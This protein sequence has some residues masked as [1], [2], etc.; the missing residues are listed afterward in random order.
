MAQQSQILLSPDRAPPRP[1]AVAPGASGLAAGTRDGQVGSVRLFVPAVL[2]LLG[3]S[4]DLPPVPAHHSH[5]ELHGFPS[6]SDAAGQVIADGELTQERAGPRLLVRIRWAFPDGRRIEERDEF[7]IDRAMAQTRFAWS[8]AKNGTELRRFEVDFGAGK[9]IAMT[10]DEKGQ[11]R[12]EEAELE[13]PPGRAFTGYGTALAVAELSLEPGADSRIVFVAFTPK[14]RTVTLRISRGAEEQIPVAGRPI[15]TDRYTLHPE[16]PFPVNLFTKAPDA[17]L[18]FTH[19][20]PAALVRAEQNLITKDDPIVVIDVTPRGPARP[21]KSS[22]G[23]VGGPG[24][25]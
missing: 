5:G 2:L 7:R 17:H 13:L 11:M 1:E 20:G 10:L 21:P 8:E 19:T 18:W 14:P 9:A 25:N 6:M 16:I 4:T 22:A 12:R 24:S 23:G 15:A 3:A